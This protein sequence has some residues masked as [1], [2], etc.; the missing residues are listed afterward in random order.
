MPIISYRANLTAAEFPFIFE[1]SGQTIIVSGVDQAGIVPAGQE[2]RDLV[3]PQIL[4]CHNVV[5]IKAGIR[6]CGFRLRIGALPEGGGG[7][8]GHLFSF[9]DGHSLTPFMFPRVE[10]DWFKPVG[11]SE[12]YTWTLQETKASTFGN[13]KYTA[14]V[15][16]V[17]YLCAGHD[18]GSIDYDDI[19]PLYKYNAGVGTFD[20]VVLTGAPALSTLHGLLGS[21]GYLILWDS[22]QIYWSSTIDPTDF[23]PSL[24]TGAGNGGIQELHGEIVTCVPTRTGFIIFGQDNAV[25][26]IYTGNLRYP[27]SFRAIK[28]CGGIT[29][30]SNQPVNPQ[31]LNLTTT[32]S[33]AAATFALTTAGLQQIEGDAAENVLTSASEFIFGE[34][35]EDY[36]EDADL[37]TRTDGIMPKAIAAVANRFLILS[38]GVPGQEFFSYALI[39][40]SDYKR[41]GKVKIDH[42]SVYEW[43]TPGVSTSGDEAANS[44]AFVG[45]DASVRTVNTNVYDSGSGPGIAFLGKYQLQRGDFCRMQAIEVQNVVQGAAFDVAVYT[46]LNGRTLQ[47][48]VTP[49][50]FE[51]SFQFRGYN[52]DTAGINHTVRFAGRF[53]LNTLVFDFIQAGF[54]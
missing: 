54:R 25:C 16:G 7:K 18:A 27:F 2:A 46:S 15:N 26:A 24:I 5:P 47:P 38:Y 39:Y 36:D 37:F 43:I 9:N 17:Q 35:F 6:S 20:A 12:P 49:M 21:F 34:H 28:G 41:W 14:N 52:L 40:D 31:Y 33:I 11:A 8:A 32:A 22:A 50:L 29:R 44:I 53:N 45:I 23:T 48:P 3:V 1:N 13:R 4:Y 42:V 19:R 51:N 30:T 10:F